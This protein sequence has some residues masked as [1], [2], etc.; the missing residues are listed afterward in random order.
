VTVQN[1][2]VVNVD[3]EKNL[4]IVRG[5]VPGAAGGTVVVRKTVKGGK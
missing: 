5:C 1:L 4:L 3:P 2:E